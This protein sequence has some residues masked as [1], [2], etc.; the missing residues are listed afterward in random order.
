MTI[1]N[2]AELE[3]QFA[4][5]VEQA[6]VNGRDCVD[7]GLL[8]TMARA[9]GCQWATYWKVSAEEMRLHPAVVWR[10]AG[11]AAE[12]LERDTHGRKLSLSE[13]TAGHVWRSRRPIWTTN[14]ALDMCLPRSLD[15]TSAGLHGGVWFALKT[16]EAVYGVVELLGPRL[17]AAS[18]ETLAAVEQLGVSLG[19]LIEKAH[20]KTM[21]GGL[22]T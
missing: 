13:G 15:A 18:A 9:V 20:L 4:R 7:V 12:P 2:P 8:S 19:R 17:D 1:S 14:V 10:D 5:I 21:E 11:V 6:Q 16:D 3:K 22:G